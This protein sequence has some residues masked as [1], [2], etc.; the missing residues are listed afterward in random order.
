VTRSDLLSCHSSLVTAFNGM[1]ATER[2]SR[3]LTANRSAL[4]FLSLFTLIF[5]VSYF[6]F[7]IAPG[8]R[9]GLTRPYT[10]LLARVVAALINL[11]GA[12]ATV[13]GTLVHSPR[14]S[15]NIAMGCDGI[16]AS[17][18]LLAGVVAFPTSWRARMIGLG[19]GIP[20]IHLI[21]L[22]RLVA[23]YC[24]GAYL[25]SMIDEIPIYVA[26]TI[27]ILIS[28]AIFIYW[29]ERFAVEDRRA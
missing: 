1:Q 14:F 29:L 28:T 23:L 11:F 15:I 7:A 5:C 8:V 19:L 3:F 26:Q 12:G 21:N 18:L 13:E 9:A 17:S 6:L 27:V 4:R 22:A 20:L 10:E 16:E 25:P 2:V 24:A